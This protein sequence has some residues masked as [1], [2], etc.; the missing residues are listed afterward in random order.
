MDVSSLL[1]LARTKLDDPLFNDDDESALFK[2]DELLEYINSALREVV[3]RGKL[4]IKKGITLDLVTGQWE[5][6]VPG[7]LIV[8]ERIDNEDNRPLVKVQEVDLE[9]RYN[10]NNSIFFDSRYYKENTA[11]LPTHY[12]Q[13]Q[14]PNNLTFYPTPTK[15]SVLTLMGTYVPTMSKDLGSSDALPKAL[16]EMYQRDLIY[17]ILAEAF[18]KPDADTYDPKKSEK[19]RQKF[20]DTFGE[21]IPAD[22]LAEIMA[23]P[24]NP[25]SMKDY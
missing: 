5:Y 12:F 3:F 13:H 24:D 21:K 6:P 17:W 1:S 2:T 22:Q 23:Y 9:N 8:I 20:I 15:D 25:G 18:D 10:Q 19:N 11:D 4:I 14:T 16:H 7:N